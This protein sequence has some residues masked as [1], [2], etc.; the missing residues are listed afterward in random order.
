M[1]DPTKQRNRV[2]S[3]NRYSVVHAEGT[4]EYWVYFKTA[5]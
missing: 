5:S 1:L 2:K 3:R 4:V